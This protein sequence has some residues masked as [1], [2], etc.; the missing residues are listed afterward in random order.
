MEKGLILKEEKMSLDPVI[1]QKEEVGDLGLSLSKRIIEDY[2]GG[3]I[4]VKDSRFPE[5]EQLLRSYKKG[6]RLFQLI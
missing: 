1:V 6:L 3:K 5:K 2:H 4:S